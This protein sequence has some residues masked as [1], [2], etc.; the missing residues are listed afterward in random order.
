M[1]FFNRHYIKSVVKTVNRDVLKS[2]W[3]IIFIIAYFGFLKKF[4]YST[5]PIVIITGFPCPAC[6]MTRAAF[7]LINLDFIGAFK[8]QP[9]I[10]GIVL[11]VFFFS[12]NRYILLRKTPEWLKWMTILLIIGMIG[13]YIWRMIVYFPGEPPMSYYPHN[14][15]TKI[16]GLM[17]WL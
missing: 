2:K 10:Y 8:T 6:G 17:K 12:F 16:F 5:C 13:F 15:L 7:Q 9:F 3:A 11:I 1:V 4:F 14:L